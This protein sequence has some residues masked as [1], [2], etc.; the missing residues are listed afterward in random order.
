MYGEHKKKSGVMKKAILFDVYGTLISTGGGSV[1]AAGEI[2][3]KA[4]ANA[5][6][7]E[8]YAHWKRLHKRRMRG[9]FLTEREIFARD[10]E[11]LYGIYGIGGDPRGDVKIMLDSLLNRRAFP[12]VAGALRSLSRRYE[13]MIASNT[14]TAPLMQNFEYNGM[15]FDRI[16]TSEE[17][18]V[19]KPDVEF[20]LEILRRTGYSAEEV[21]FMGDSPEEDVSAPQRLGIFSVHI[22]RKGAGGCSPDMSFDRVPDE[23]PDIGSGDI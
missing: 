17:L 4:G 21:I 6:P 23:L 19:Y 22:D 12:E 9:A 2:L 3:R 7:K 15:S 11:E 5:D 10:L 13:L 20:Y 18:G 14:D 1:E 16:F 8:F